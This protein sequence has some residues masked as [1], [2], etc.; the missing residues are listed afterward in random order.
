M[1]H[2]I[3][4][5][6]LTMIYKSLMI[7]PLPYSSAPSLTTLLLA[8]PTL[9]LL[10]FF[11]LFK[12]TKLVSS[13]EVL[14][15]LFR[16]PDISCS[17]SYLCSSL[18]H[19]GLC[20]NITSSERSSPI[21]LAISSSSLPCIPLTFFVFLHIT[22]QYLRLSFSNLLEVHCF[23]SSLEC[24]LQGGREFSCSLMY[25]QHLEEDL[26]GIKYILNE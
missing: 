10:T 18:L 5:K 25:S 8:H 4:S 3:I 11:L 20:S 24:K 1:V 21:Y 19:S 2:R 6:P 7:W 23:S 17:S 22:Y 12:K 13:S 15:F 9:E 16:L 14:N 26:I